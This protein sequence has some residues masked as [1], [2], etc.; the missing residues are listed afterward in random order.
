M[1]RETPRV[2]YFALVDDG[3]TPEDAG[4]LVRRI[5]TRPAPTD[6]SIGRDLLW[7]KTEYLRRYYLGHNDQDHVEVSEEFANQLIERW[8]AKWAAEDAR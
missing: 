6:E 4:G 5:H 3:G 1:E 7:H 2:Q 8:R